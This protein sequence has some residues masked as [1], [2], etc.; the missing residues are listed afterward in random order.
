MDIVLIA[1]ILVILMGMN[2]VATRAVIRDDFSGR[3]QKI[4]QLL[5]VWLIPLLGALVVLG[6]HR[7]EEKSS[8][9]YRE[10]PDPGDDFAASGRG[11][12]S[13]LRSDADGPD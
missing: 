7:R 5:S 2:L 11:V 12:R 10:I 8:G 4:A 3:G 1:L 13:T 9:K 6:V